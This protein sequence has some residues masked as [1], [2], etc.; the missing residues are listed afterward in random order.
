M[1]TVKKPLSPHLQ[2]YKPQITSMMSITHR[3]TGIFLSIGAL[4]L[5][6]WIISIAA[7]P[8]AYLQVSGHIQTWYGKII[9]I[10]FAFSFYYHLGNGIRHLFWD[11][12]MGLE[13][14]AAYQSGYAVIIISIVLTIA[15]TFLGG[16]L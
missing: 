2:V 1:S 5:S 16:L 15:T 10:L 14:K 3:A 7:G 9:L 11:L 12:G 6:F 4:F 13:L 8:E